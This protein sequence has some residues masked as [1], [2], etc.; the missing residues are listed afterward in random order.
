MIKWESHLVIATQGNSLANSGSF[1][2]H[3]VSVRGNRRIQVVVRS[4]IQ[5]LSHTQKSAADVHKERPLSM[6][7]DPTVSDDGGQFFGTARRQLGS[8]IAENR[9]IQPRGRNALI[10][11]PASENM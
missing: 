10:W 4:W 8:G 9:L 1:T 5:A 6:I 7:F 3:S 11:F 2:A